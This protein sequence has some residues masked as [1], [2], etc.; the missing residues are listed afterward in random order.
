MQSHKGA[1]P[2]DMNYFAQHSFDP[3]VL[4]SGRNTTLHTTIRWK[5]WVSF[6]SEAEEGKISKYVNFDIFFDSHRNNFNKI[7]NSKIF[8]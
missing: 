7:A 5:I 3:S 4:N 1:P 2:E 6:M 8:T